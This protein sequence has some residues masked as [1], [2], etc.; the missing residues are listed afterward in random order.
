LGVE[1]VFDHVTLAVRDLDEA[2]RFFGALGFEVMKAVVISGEVMDAY[3][4]VP[5]LEADHV[6]LAVPDAEPHQE[7]QLLRYHHPVV[8]DEHV[9]DLSRTGLNH[10]CFRVANIEA[11]MDDLIAAGFETRNTLMT[12][13]DRKLVFFVGPANAVIE[14]AEWL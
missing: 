2:V 4:G 14:L 13:H 6:T 1:A 8:I 5:G 12:F 11:A 7:V 10:V 3:M 9:G